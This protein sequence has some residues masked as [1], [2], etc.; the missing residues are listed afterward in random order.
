MQN[1]TD[2]CSHYPGLR[3]SS[4]KIASPVPQ[5]N[6]ENVRQEI[7]TPV[8]GKSATTTSERGGGVMT[9]TSALTAQLPG[10]SGQ[11]ASSTN[12][13]GS[14]GSI[15]GHNLPAVPAKLPVSR[16]ALPP[17][18]SSTLT[19][20]DGTFSSSSATP[21][22]SGTGK[23]HSG[24]SGSTPKANGTPRTPGQALKS[25]LSFSKR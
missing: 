18:L 13:S 12:K 14:N 25:V 11:S 23:A 16:M 5:T 15:N 17:A 6:T 24:V 21:D 1:M 8:P 2:S 20:P 19:S 4:P 9:S 22:Y 3:H 10:Q 7:I